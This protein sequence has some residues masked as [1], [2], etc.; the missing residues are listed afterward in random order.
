MTGEQY[1]ALLADVSANGPRVAIIIY[2]QQVLD[3][4][5][6]QRACAESG[7]TPEFLE[8]RGTDCEAA[9]LARSLEQRRHHTPEQ[10]RAWSRQLRSDGFSLREIAAMVGVS[11]ETIRK[12][13]SEDESVK[14]LT[15]EPAGECHERDTENGRDT[16][17]GDESTPVSTAKPWADATPVDR[18][19]AVLRELSDA[20]QRLAAKVLAAV[21]T[22]GIGEALERELRDRG[23][24][25][26][27]K[28]N[29]EP[30]YRG[31]AAEERRIITTVPLLD[32]LL[33]AIDAAVSVAAKRHGE[34]TPW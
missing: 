15:L 20:A 23:I 32:G 26:S 11:H 14:K 27:D 31:A 4:R 19:P 25:V 13:L 22:V 30:G 16:G 2:E 33:S 5:N 24:V 28:R 29:V 10:Q 12:H 17:T 34:V 18:T 6:R 7:R 8:F 1:A 9:A 3:G 21:R